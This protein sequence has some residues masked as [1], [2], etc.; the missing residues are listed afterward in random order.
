MREIEEKKRKRVIPDK[1]RLHITGSDVQRVIHQMTGVP[2]KNLEKED[3]SRLRSLDTTLNK[4]ILGQK[5]A[6]AGIVSSLKRSRVGISSQDRPIG[7]F[8]F[9]GPTGV[10]KTELV[11]VLAEEFFADPKAL[12][13]I[14]MS[15]FQDKSSAS[16][17]IGTTA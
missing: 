4:R 1:D 9:L 17:L 12:I 2:L 14:D 13:K 16:K 15:E 5:D 10:G 11:K 6:I 8:L 3:L 7:S